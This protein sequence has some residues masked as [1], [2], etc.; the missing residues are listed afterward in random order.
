MR[1]RSL[2]CV[3]ATLIFIATFAMV[4]SPPQAQMVQRGT[5]DTTG[6][7]GAQLYAESC[8]T[9]HGLDGRGKEASELGFDVATPDFTDCQFA[10]R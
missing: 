6:K 8:A 3:V 1:I 2:A 7:T 10:P 5:V 9:C 4:Q